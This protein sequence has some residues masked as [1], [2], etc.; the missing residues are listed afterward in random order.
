MLSPAP[1]PSSGD[2]CERSCR[3]SSWRGSSWPSKDGR[4]NYERLHTGSLFV[5]LNVGAGDKLRLD[6]TGMVG[7]VFGDLDGVAPGLRVTLTWWKLDFSTDD[8]HVI[9][10]HDVNAS[11]LAL[12][13]SLG[14]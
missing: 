14:G 4:Y 10:V 1:L 11:F 5:G 12:G 13:A 3:R 7:G 6:A 8:E 9:E 2:E